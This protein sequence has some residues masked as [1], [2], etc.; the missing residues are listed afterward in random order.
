MTAGVVAFLVLAGLAVWLGSRGRGPNPREPFH[1]HDRRVQALGDSEGE[2]LDHVC[3]HCASPP[4]A[5]L[6][7]HECDPTCCGG[8]P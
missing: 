6:Q 1:L 3:A 7:M 4:W 5:Y 8:V 2:A